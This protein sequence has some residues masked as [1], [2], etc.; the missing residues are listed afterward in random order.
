[1]TQILK[2]PRSE[3]STPTKTTRP[4]KRPRDSTGPG[5]YKEALTNIKMVVFKETYLEDILTEDD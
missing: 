3:D 5:I 1:L 2:I 4:P